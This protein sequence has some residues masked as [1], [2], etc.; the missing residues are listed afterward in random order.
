MQLSALTARKRAWTVERSRVKSILPNAPSA[1]KRSAEPVP[2][3]A[4]FVEKIIA[5]DIFA[6]WKIDA[7]V[8]AMLPE[9]THWRSPIHLCR[10]LLRKCKL[11]INRFAASAAIKQRTIAPDFVLCA[12]TGSTDEGA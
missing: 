9:I 12:E 8:A 11:R 2:H 10:S 4:L 6:R 5:G 3:H 7:L 1:Q